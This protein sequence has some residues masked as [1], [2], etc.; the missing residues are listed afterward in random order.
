M[1]QA[2]KKY[3][4]YYLAALL[5]ALGLYYHGRGHAYENPH[6]ISY[7]E[8]Y[9]RFHALKLEDCKTYTQ[10]VEFHKENGE[11]CYFDAK[12]KCWYLPK[13]KDRRNADYCFSNA[14]A[15]LYP[16]DPRS[17]L[18]AVIINTLVQYGIDCC[19]EWEYINNKLYWAQYHHELAEFYQDLISNGHVK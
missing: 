2:L 17:K 16:S 13:L 10:K 3:W 8:N 18:I 6:T 19:D 11:R 9:Y 7:I 14:G 4:H 15:L 12:Q 1:K 5:F